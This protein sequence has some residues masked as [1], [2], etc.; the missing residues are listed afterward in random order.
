VPAVRGSVGAGNMI[1]MLPDDAVPV[2]VNV[3]ESWLCSMKLSR[4]LKKTGEYTYTNAAYAKNSRNALTF[5]LDV[6]M[7]KIVFKEKSR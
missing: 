1:I 3:N 5:D 6:S 2:R 4:G 7:G